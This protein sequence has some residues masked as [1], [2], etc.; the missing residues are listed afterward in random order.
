MKEQSNA[1]HEAGRRL[2]RV[3]VGIAVQIEG[4]LR[5]IREFPEGGVHSLRRRM[6]KLGSILRLARKH[7]PAPTKQRVR[8]NISLLKSAF[9]TSRDADVMRRLAT[10]LGIPEAAVGFPKIAPP[11]KIKVIEQ[12]W[13]AAVELSGQIGNL[14]LHAMTWKDVASSFLRASVKERSAGKEA[15]QEATPE[16]LH[17]WR[18][19]TKALY[20]QMLFIHQITGRMKMPMKLADRLGRLLGRHHDLDVLTLRLKQDAGSSRW[21]EEIKRRQKKLRRRIFRAADR[22]HGKPL[23][24]SAKRL[25]EILASAG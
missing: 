16:A 1:E 10:D 18:K 13:K 24:K 23:A 22:L 19:K 9:A 8:Q 6:K 17:A 3:L 15:H 25:A 21:L 7:I 14:S 20:Y 4:D 5:R 12:T 11:A 2:H